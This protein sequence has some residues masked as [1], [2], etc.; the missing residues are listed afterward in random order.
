MWHD[1]CGGRVWAF[2]E[3]LICGKCGAQEQQVPPMPTGLE[4]MQLFIDTLSTIRP[5]GKT[6]YD[7][8]LGDEV[9]GFALVA[10]TEAV[11]RPLLAQLAD[12]TRQRDEAFAA[13]RAAEA[14]ERRQDAMSRD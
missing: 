11:G 10:V 12:M 2:K 9:L 3:G 6:Y 4:L 14:E 7:G 5:N 1:N 13:G 8:L